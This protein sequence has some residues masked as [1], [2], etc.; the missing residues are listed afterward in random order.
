MMDWAVSYDWPGRYTLRGEVV[1]DDGTVFFAEVPITA[2]DRSELTAAYATGDRQ[3]FGA[4]ARAIC[5][6]Y[7][8]NG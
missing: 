2:S 5:E 7:V 6:A 1:R 4:T 8:T 3:I